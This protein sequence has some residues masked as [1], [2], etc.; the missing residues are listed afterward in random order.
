MDYLIAPNNV[1]VGSGDTAPISGTPGE[2]TDGNPSTNTPATQWPAYAWNGMQKELT[3]VIQAAG[4]TLDRNNLT[5]VLTAIKSLIQLS[6]G[7]YWTDTGAANTYVITPSPA[8]TAF[9]GGQ[10]FLVVPANV[11]TTSSTLNVNGLG[12]K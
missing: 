7:T 5:Q 10:R 4:A 11:N 1:P 2:A 3:N 8:I 6:A 12:A 9:T